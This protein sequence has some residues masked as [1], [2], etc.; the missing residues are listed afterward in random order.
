[1][2]PLGFPFFCWIIITSRADALIYS[3]W[4]DQRGAASLIHTG[5]VV[6]KSANRGVTKGTFNSRKTHDKLIY[7]LLEHNKVTQT[8]RFNT[9]TKSNLNWLQMPTIEN[10]QVFS[11]FDLN[12]RIG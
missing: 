4:E 7:V 11:Q 10:C 9:R 1:M 8:Q 3:D 5:E 6:A 2:D 12:I